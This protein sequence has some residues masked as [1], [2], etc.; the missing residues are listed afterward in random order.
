MILR[1]KLDRYKTSL[2][3]VHHKDNYKLERNRFS[4]KLVSKTKSSP[5]LHS[6]EFNC[7]WNRPKE[8]NDQE[9]YYTEKE[10]KITLFNEDELKMVCCVKKY[11]QSFINRDSRIQGIYIS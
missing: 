4:L 2:N 9:A 7:N 5:C 1:V 3:L 10:P 11:G 6:W 8:I